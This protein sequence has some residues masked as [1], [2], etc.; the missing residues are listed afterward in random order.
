[1]LFIFL[2]FGIVGGE[3]VH[4]QESPLLLNGTEPRHGDHDAD[5]ETYKT[6]L[7]TGVV[8]M[9][10]ELNVFDYFDYKENWRCS[11]GDDTAYSYHEYNPQ[12]GAD[13]LKNCIEFCFDDSTCTYVNAQHDS[14]ICYYF[15][16]TPCCP[17]IPGFDKDDSNTYDIATDSS[18]CGEGQEVTNQNGGKGTDAGISEANPNVHYWVK[19]ITIAPTNSPT[20]LPTVFPTN[21]PTVFPTNS[22]TNLPTVFPTNSPTNSPTK[23]PTNSPSAAP[24]ETAPTLPPSPT[25]KPSTSPTD[26]PTFPPTSG[27]CID[28]AQGQLE[29]DKDCGGPDCLPCVYDK[30]CVLDRDCR[31]D[32]H[33][34]CENDPTTNTPPYKCIYKTG[35]PTQYPTTAYPSSSPTTDSPTQRPSAAPPAPIIYTYKTIKEDCT[36]SDFTKIVLG[37]SSTLAFTVAVA[38]VGFWYLL[39]RSKLAAGGGS[40]QPVATAN[41]FKSSLYRKADPGE[42]VALFA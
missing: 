36:V 24:T 5:Y 40:Y 35:S 27:L 7:L 42:R 34:H 2:L 13:K 3:I 38:A 23:S 8:T 16:Q 6:E 41:R 11:Y 19:T 1:M 26:A 31:S 9:D 12:D 22:P 18:Q 25:I 30:I 32:L 15:I 28:G 37:I 20:N 29:T 17:G 4:P 21:L 39:E 33:L 14:G 10:N